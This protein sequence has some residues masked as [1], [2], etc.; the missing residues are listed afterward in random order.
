[1]NTL[2]TA[3]SQITVCVSEGHFRFSP[4]DIVRL[5][6][7]SN[8]TFIYFTNRKPMLTARVLKDFEMVLAQFG[9]IRTHRSH[10]INGRHI[11]QVNKN[12]NIIM[13]DNSKAEISRRKRTQVM[14]VLAAA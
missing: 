12:G 9:F 7:S 5:E 3:A 2:H 4:A 11:M 6:A 8:Y 14:G 10:L 13:T 1:M